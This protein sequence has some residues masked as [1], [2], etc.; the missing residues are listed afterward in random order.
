[1]M[2]RLQ[3]NL[4]AADV[5]WS[6]PHE[7]NASP[8]GIPRQSSNATSSGNRSRAS[9]SIECEPTAIRGT[10]PAGN[11]IH[12]STA[13]AKP[14]I[15]P[16][17]GLVARFAKSKPKTVPKRTPQRI[18]CETDR[19]RMIP[20]SRPPNAPMNRQ[21]RTRLACADKP[22]TLDSSGIIIAL[23]GF[24]ISPLLLQLDRLNNV[25]RKEKLDRPIRHHS[26]FPLKSRKLGKID[27]AP[28]Q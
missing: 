11:T 2:A 19:V 9:K 13:N 4:A 24:V 6:S 10:M 12:S 5:E 7:P 16:A 15:N 25:A 3:L 28:H 8:T 22:L 20:C 27:A 1:M 23:R 14:Q 26:N 18:D 21:S 17:P